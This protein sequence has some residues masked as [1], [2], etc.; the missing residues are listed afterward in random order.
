MCAAASSRVQIIV[1]PR[2]ARVA[3]TAVRTAWRVARRD[4][5]SRQ[6]AQHARAAAFEER[7]EVRAL[8]RGL[9]GSLFGP[10]L[11]RRDGRRAGRHPVRGTAPTHEA[12]A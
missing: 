3:S 6:G 5:A 2:Q 10:H 8:R 4:A 9:G 7:L 11:L 1:Q 12:D